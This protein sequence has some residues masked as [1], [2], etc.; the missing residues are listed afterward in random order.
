MRIMVGLMLGLFVLWGGWW[1]A[2]SSAEHRAAVAFFADR[3]AAGFTAEYSS[4][5]VAGFPSR[6]D[7]TV[8]DVALGDPAAGITWRAPFAQLLALSYNPYHFIAALPHRQELA[9][10]VGTFSVTSDRMEASLRVVPGLAFTLDE[11]VAVADQPGLTAST[12]WQVTAATMRLA[13]RRVPGRLLAQQIGA[14]ADHITPNPMLKAMLDPTGA[15]P[16]TLDQAYLDAEAGFDTAID[17]HSTTHPPH[18]TDLTLR[19][20]HI[21]W[22]QMLLSATGKVTVDAEGVPEGRITI[23]AKDWKGMVAVAVTLGLVRPE[24]A[25]TVQNMLA[26]LAKGSPDPDVVELPL[27]FQK[28]WMSLGPLPVGAAPRLR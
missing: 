11:I 22:G 24:L 14:E 1:F 18:L 19:D 7:L 9:T 20:G 27:E 16:D 12:G 25:P 4:L 5:D 21:T 8:N 26:E 6:L 17:R 10:P 23:R 28:G 13:T 3:R 15:L 2:A